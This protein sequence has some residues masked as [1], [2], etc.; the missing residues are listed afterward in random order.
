MREEVL[1]KSNKN[2]MRRIKEK[3]PTYFDELRKGQHPDYFV[4]SCSDSRVSPTAITDMPLGRMF[5]HRNIANQVR[6]DDDSFT[7]GLY[8]GLK[9]LEVKKI[10][11]EGHTFCG[12]VIAAWHGNEEEHLKPWLNHIRDS[13]PEKEEGNCLSEEEL[14]RINVI[15]QVEN[16]KTHPV[17][18]Q[19]GEGVDV[20]GC[21][22]HVESGEIEWLETDDE[23]R[24]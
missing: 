12:G 22:F 7:A 21:L 20:I 2:F 10:I 16:L 1:D 23:R 15:R 17:F 19:Y 9:H 6:R 11:I 18:K 5:V 14:A 24:L 3:N 13:L 8:Y 4:L